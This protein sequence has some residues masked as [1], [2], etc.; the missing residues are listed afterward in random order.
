M[1]DFTTHKL[2]IDGPA[3]K[4]ETILNEPKSTPRAIAIIAH[5]HPL[6]GGTMDNKVVHT[7][8]RSALELGFIAVKFNFRGIGNSEGTYDHGKGEIDDVRCVVETI[9]NQYINQSIELPVVLCGFSFGG[10]VQ[11]HAAQ[12]I[13]P[14]SMILVA[15]SVEN[16]DAPAPPKNTQIFI[17]H[18][19]QDE[20]I[21]LNS[22]L[23]WATP[24]SLPIIVMPG[25][26]HF[27]HGQLTILKNT[28]LQFHFAV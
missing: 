3:G 24:Y 25:A 23:S 5:P 26:T 10:A 17:I 27:F 4:L 11:L 2:F 15:P 20:V 1:S 18:G 28:I 22:V 21:S 16:F 9:R 6:Y 14:H 7:L 12:H 19:D 8:F 13:Q